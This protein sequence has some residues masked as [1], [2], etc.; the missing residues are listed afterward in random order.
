M[1]RYY[2]LCI[3]L[4]LLLG[5]HPALVAQKAVKVYRTK[6][7]NLYSQAQKDSIADLGFPIAE[8]DLTKK[9]DTSYIDFD[10]LPKS[11]PDEQPFVKRHLPGFDHNRSLL[12][13]K[14]YFKALESKLS[15][16]LSR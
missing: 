9:G 16:M 5:T 12:F 15:M 14:W 1:T 6:E 10:I 8:T 2:T 7:G 4:L 3:G 11:S 13:G